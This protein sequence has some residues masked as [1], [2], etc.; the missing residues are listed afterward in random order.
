M[1]A[2]MNQSKPTRGKIV[3]THRGLEALRPADTAY[4]IAD[5]RC[6]GL[7][8]RIAPS[9]V[10]TWDVAFRVRRRGIFRRVSLGPFPAVT[11]EAARDRTAALIR[12]AKA[13]RDLL[14]E[15][16]AAQAAA[17]ARLTVEQLVE[18]YLVKQVRGRLRTAHEMELRFARIFAPLMGRYIDEIRRRDLREMLD[19]VAERGAPREAQQRRQLTRVLFRWALGQDLVETDP[20][21]GLASYGNSPR[22]DRVLSLQEIRI[23]WPWLGEGLPDSYAEA[24]RL[25]LV[26][27]ARIGEVAG[28][29]GAEV[30]QEKWLWTLPPDRS[31]NGRAR[32][33]PIVGLAREIIEPRIRETGTGSLFTTDQGL[34]LTSNHVASLLVKHRKKIPVPDFSSH[35]LRRTAATNLVELGFPYDLVAA[36]LGHE[37]GSRDVRTLIR[38]YVRSDLLDRKRYALTAWG[39]HVR[40]ALSSNESAS[41]IVPLYAWDTRA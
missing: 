34:T 4:R 40:R 27:G 16:R 35:D 22:R 29:C 2:P 11:L 10:K 8:V 23:L 17:E 37:T 21:A 19:A 6:P 13:G 9:G 33:T 18:R 25:Q 3:L 31:K 36:V 5:L 28:M 1:N 24:L 38:H 41:N 20:S 30:D 26:L 12:A 15:E 7:A 39:D 14:A 32:V